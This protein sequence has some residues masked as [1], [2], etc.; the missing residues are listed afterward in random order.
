VKTEVQKI[1]NILRHTFE[2]NA[3]HGSSVKEALADIPAD[4]VHARVADSHSILELVT[5]MTAWR[6]Y[7]AEKLKGNDTFELTDEQNFPKETDWSRALANLEQSQHDLIKALE[8]TPDDRLQEVVPN[9][10]FKFYTMLHGIIHH[11]LYHTGQIVLIKKSHT[12]NRK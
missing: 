4:T 1:I 11:D 5:H 8:S 10:K 2:K 9:R 7:V 6:N 12:N 3:W